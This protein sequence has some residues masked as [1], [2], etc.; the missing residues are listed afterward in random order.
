MS[1]NLLK[2]FFI[3]G[4]PHSPIR[5]LPMTEIKKQIPSVLSFYSFEGINEEVKLIKRIIENTNQLEI[6]FP[7]KFSSSELENYFNDNQE[8]KK[9]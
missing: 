7:K 3:C 9:K 5:S 4:V 6:I 2:F 8:S 1:E